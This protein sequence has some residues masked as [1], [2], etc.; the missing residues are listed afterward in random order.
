MTK[1]ERAE[2]FREASLYLRNHLMPTQGKMLDDAADELDPP[3]KID[4]SLRGLIVAVDENDHVTPFWANEDGLYRSSDMQVRV[5]D[6]PNLIDTATHRGWTV[7]KLTPE[8]IG[9]KGRRWDDLSTAQKVGFT[10][11]V[12]NED[13]CKDIYRAAIDIATRREE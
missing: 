9:F 12:S 4:T 10:H 11:T 6:W 1:K 7:R 8:D 5:W 13:Y 2:A 3:A